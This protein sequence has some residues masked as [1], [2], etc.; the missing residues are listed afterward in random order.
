[1]AENAADDRNAMSFAEL[2]SRAWRE[3]PPVHTNR[4]NLLIHII[5]VPLFVFGHVLLIAGLF[6]TPWLF[7]AALLAVVVSLVAQKW[8]HS[9]ERNQVRP[10]TGGRD[11][12]RRLY[13]EQFCNF[14]RFMLSGRWY[15][16]LRASRSVA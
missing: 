6:I 12:L 2:L 14:W 1:M 3:T 9:L 16:S 15:A 5:A 4:A 10:F 7:V 8:G 13:A 11:F